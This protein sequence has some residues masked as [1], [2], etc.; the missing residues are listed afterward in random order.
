MANT[1]Y[2][3]VKVQEIRK[4]LVHDLYV[5]VQNSKNMRLNSQNLVAWVW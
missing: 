3:K 5:A 4:S 2:C 1:S